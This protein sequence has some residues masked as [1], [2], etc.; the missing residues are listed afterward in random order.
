MHTDSRLT[1]I[2]P[3]CLLLVGV[4]MALQTGLS[5]SQQARKSDSQSVPYLERNRLQEAYNHQLILSKGHKPSHPCHL[6]IS[7]QLERQ[8]QPLQQPE[9]DSSSTQ[10]WTPTE[11]EQIAKDYIARI[12]GIAIQYKCSLY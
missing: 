1:W 7:P 12:D 9:E 11:A 4:F 10:R 2:H 5:P 3:L 8:K 6:S